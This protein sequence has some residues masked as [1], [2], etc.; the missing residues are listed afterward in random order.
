[1]KVQKRRRRENK[2]DYGKRLKLLKSRK[3]RIILRI[4]NKYVSAQYVES[5]EARDSV[6]IS[7]SSKELL[8]DGWPEKSQGSLKSIPASYLL[9][10]LISKKIK[11]KKLDE[12]VIIDFGMSRNIHK[13]RIY[14]FVKGLKD[15]GINFPVGD[16]EKIFPS[17]DRLGGEHMKNKINVEEIKSKINKGE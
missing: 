17:K 12:N 13:S 10:V 7:V 2:T 1:M 16:E 3:S 15:S 4:S 6:K 8:K 5:L 14:S 9:G 11:E